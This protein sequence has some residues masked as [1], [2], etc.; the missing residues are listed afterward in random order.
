MIQEELLIENQRVDID[1]EGKIQRTLTLNS[2]GSITAKQSSYSNTI[3]LPKTANNIKIFD[4]LSI[5]GNTS[6]KPYERLVCSYLYN[7]IPV[8]LNGYAIIDKVTQD[9]FEITIYN[10]VIELAEIL[11]D[12]LLNDLDFTELSHSLTVNKYQEV[13]NDDSS[14]FTYSIPM[15]MVN[16]NPDDKNYE[17]FGGTGFTDVYY[18]NELQP[19]VKHEFIFNKIFEEAGYIVEGD[20]FDDTLLYDNFKTEYS[21]ITTGQIIITPTGDT[22]T[23]ISKSSDVLSVNQ[24]ENFVFSREDVI[25][26]LIGSGNTELT[27]NDT[28]FTCHFT[29]ILEMTI[30]PDFNF[31]YAEN[32]KI[33]YTQNGVEYLLRVILGDTDTGTSA[34]KKRINVSSGDTISFSIYAESETSGLNEKIEYT[35]GFDC[36]FEAYTNLD[37]L[38]D[39]NL[40]KLGKTKQLDFIKDVAN[41]YGLLINK[42]PN[43][44]K[45]VVKNINNLLNSK[46]TAIDY[47]TKLINVKEETFTINY[48]QRNTL[49][50]KYLKTNEETDYSG[51]A[52]DYFNLSNKIA[53]SEVSFYTSLFETFNKSTTIIDNFG[54]DYNYHITY[55]LLTI[56]YIDD[57]VDN[58]A[59]IPYYEANENALMLCRLF[60]S[61]FKIDYDLGF[62]NPPVLVDNEINEYF[63]YPQRPLEFSEMLDNYYSSFINLLGR[64]KAITVN[65]NLNLLDIHLFDFYK[66]IYLKQTG[67]YYYVNKL[68]YNVASPITEAELVEIPF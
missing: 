40:I 39:G 26:G 45:I 53:T 11:K 66:L 52:D 20:L 62:K 50:W 23:T 2:L 46:T 30:S 51:F 65:F 42:N 28:G 44:N 41:R 33:N 32:K 60:K 59:D 38:I 9:A 18:L 27:F 15:D 17:P 5:N 63:I 34:F 37:S 3:K 55:P 68:K 25:D 8:F 29:G 6:N 7:S 22:S 10:G 35:Y 61:D 48:G 4:G 31:S 49:E 56:E 16:R 58:I 54:I 57:G 67:K 21:P 36:D 1:G 43:E 24:T 14:P 13:I 47:S 64:Y 12:K 19:L